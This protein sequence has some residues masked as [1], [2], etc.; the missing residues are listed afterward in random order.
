MYQ[1]KETLLDF[2]CSEFEVDI[3][4]KSYSHGPA[5]M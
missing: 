2:N 5:I 4:V 1:L 3:E